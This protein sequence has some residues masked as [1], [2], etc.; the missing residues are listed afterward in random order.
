VTRLPQTSVI[1]VTHSRNHYKL[2]ISG[3]AG[4]IC[5]LYQNSKRFESRR[6]FPFQAAELADQIHQK[7]FVIVS[8][9]NKKCF[10]QVHRLWPWRA[11]N[12]GQQSSIGAAQAPEDDTDCCFLT[13]TMPCSLCPRQ[14]PT[15]P[16]CCTC[17]CLLLCFCNWLL[18]RC[19]HATPCLCHV[20]LLCMLP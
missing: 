11:T 5:K 2:I 18:Q 13:F 3:H 6:L 15:P 14:P 9:A 1:Y 12:G 19:M 10:R 4:R 17:S 7:A 20:E 16:H 8:S